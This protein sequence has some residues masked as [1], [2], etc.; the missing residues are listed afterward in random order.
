MDYCVRC[1]ACGTDLLVTASQAGGTCV[2]KCGT[3]VAVPRLSELRLGAGQT[4]YSTTAVDRVN[5]MLKRGELPTNRDCPICGAPADKVKVLGIQCEKA[6]STDFQD[7][8]I[9]A[10]AVFG[11]LAAL[12]AAIRPFNSRAGEIHGRE[13]RLEVPLRFCSSCILQLTPSTRKR[14][15]R[16]YLNSDPAYKEVFDEFPTASVDIVQTNT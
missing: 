2:C 6:T 15:L 7:D 1:D 13:T 5:G 9:I 12:A 3:N 14:D 11:W 10:V 4:R 8:T 16:K